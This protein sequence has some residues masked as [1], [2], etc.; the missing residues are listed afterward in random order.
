MRSWKA[1]PNAFEGQMFPTIV[2]LHYAWDGGDGTSW[3]ERF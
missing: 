3:V 2:I 1:A